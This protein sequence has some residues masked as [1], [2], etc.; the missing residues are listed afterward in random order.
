MKRLI[1]SI[2]YVSIISLL[3]QTTTFGVNSP[4]VDEPEV[5][6]YNNYTA[7]N[8]EEYQRYEENLLT[9]IKSDNIGLQTSCAYFLGEMKSGKSMIHLLKLARYG[10]TEESRIIAGLSL[11]KIESDIGM[12]LL[13]GLRKSDDSE[14]VRRSFDRIYKKYIS[15]ERSFDNQNS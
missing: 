15:D 8:D 9:G 2:V 11:Y 7:L 6:R 10:D 3:L 5:S 12:H 14:K 13:K 4:K 1:I